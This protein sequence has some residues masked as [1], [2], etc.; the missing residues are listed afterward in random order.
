MKD[1]FLT[2]H[3][4]KPTNTPSIID[5]VFTYD[6]QQLD[7]EYAS[8]LGKSDHGLIKFSYQYQPEKIPPKVVP[9]LKRADFEK[10]KELLNIDWEDEFNDSGD[11]ID[12]MWHTFERIYKTAEKVCVPTRTVKIGKRPFKYRFD[13]KTLSKK[14]KKYRLWKRFIESHDAEVYLEYC[15]CRNQVRRMTR[16][17]RRDFEKEIAKSA[18]TNS[19][20]FW[21]YVNA[22]TKIKSAIPDLLTE[23]DK[24]AETD[25]EKANVLGEFF[26]LAFLLTNL[27]HPSR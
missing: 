15:K 22:K 6:N 12:K 5:L 18:K 23:S 1:S 26:F 24:L 9:D 20:A 14:K 2:Q 8:P 16:N 27:P 17:A 10:M 19:K 4:N 25:Q 13:R 11:D 21:T 3:V 7:I